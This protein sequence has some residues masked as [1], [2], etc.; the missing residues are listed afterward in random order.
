MRRVVRQT[1]DMRMDYVHYLIERALEFRNLALTMRDPF[2]A[3]EFHHLADLCA[4]K[5]AALDR[6]P[7]E[8]SNAGLVARRS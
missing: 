7:E 8:P 6:Y 1:P 2:A 4:E 5:A 3:R